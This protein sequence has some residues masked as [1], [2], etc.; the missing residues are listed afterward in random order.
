MESRATLSDEGTFISGL[1][2][3]LWYIA[4]SQKGSLLAPRLVNALFGSQHVA[5]PQSVCTIVL[6]ARPSAV[7]CF[8]A[9]WLRCQSILVIN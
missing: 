9:L 6:L 3:L 1:S 2:V 7:C 4:M 8:L 5:L